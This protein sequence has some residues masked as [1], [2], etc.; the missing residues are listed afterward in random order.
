[1]SVMNCPDCLKEFP[2]I[3]SECPYC[4]WKDTLEDLQ[5]VGL[6]RT[7]KKTMIVIGVIVV[8]IVIFSVAGGSEGEET[9][10]ES[11]GQETPTQ[12]S[13]VAGPIQNVA[14]SS[15]RPRPKKTKVKKKLDIPC[16]VAIG[17]CYQL[18]KRYQTGKG[19]QRDPEKALHLYRKSCLGGNN[20]GCKAAKSKRL[21]MAVPK[22]YE[23]LQSIQNRYQDL[24]GKNMRVHDVVLVAATYYNCRFRSRRKWRAFKLSDPVR[25]TR[26]HGYCKRGDLECD[27]LAEKLADGGELQRTLILRYRR[28][29]ICAEG[30]IEIVRIVE[31]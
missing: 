19:V 16:N 23:S 12:P 27:R 24:I 31:D 8:L 20:A 11:L 9:P 13:N 6:S 1:M 17:E 15:D 10:K 3:E 28:N 14:A 18:G 29:R 7:L 25:Y 30:Q 4:G 5:G 21:L 2:E 26:A 22:D